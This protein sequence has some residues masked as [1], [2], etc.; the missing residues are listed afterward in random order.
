MTKEDHVRTSCTTWWHEHYRH[1]L[2]PSRPGVLLPCLSFPSYF[3]PPQFPFYSSCSPL[4][5]HSLG[6]VFC[7]FSCWTRCPHSLEE[8][9][10]GGCAALLSGRCSLEVVRFRRGTLQITHALLR[11]PP[12]AGRFAHADLSLFHAVFCKGWAR[13]NCRASSLAL[14]ADTNAVKVSADLHHPCLWWRRGRGST[15][16]STASIIA[17]VASP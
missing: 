6:R 8:N 14:H 9:T 10:Y 7:H 5:P 16:F 4:S 11:Q 2:P 17:V 1:V 12:S 15:F 3:R 13:K